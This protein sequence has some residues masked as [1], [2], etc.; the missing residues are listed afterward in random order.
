MK[1]RLVLKSIAVVFLASIASASAQDVKIGVLDFVGPSAGGLRDQL[2]TELSNAGY[3]VVNSATVDQA[4]AGKNLINGNAVD[5]SVAIAIGKACG[6]T[7]LVTG[8]ALGPL[9]VAQIISA[10]NATV[11]GATGPDAKGLAAAIKSTI[12]TNKAAL[13]AN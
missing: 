11:V 12:D 5:S 13:L 2:V 3:S 8:K 10:S 1:N 7:V 6:A 9:N 4:A